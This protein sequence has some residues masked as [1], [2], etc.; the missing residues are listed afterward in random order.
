MGALMIPLPSFFGKRTDRQEDYMTPPP[1]H[2]P[3]F[4]ITQAM[5]DSQLS[6]PGQGDTWLLGQAGFRGWL[7][8]RKGSGVHGRRKVYGMKMLS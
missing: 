8:C 4:G 2:T 7:G 6:H 3:V 5:P 1:P